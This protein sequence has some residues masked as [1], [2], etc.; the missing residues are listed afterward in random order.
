MERADLA[1]VFA[2][3]FEGATDD[4]CVGDGQLFEGSLLRH[5]GTND[6]WELTDEGA[7]LADFG[8]VGIDP[9]ARARHRNGVAVLHADGQILGQAAAR[10]VGL[11]F[12]AHAADDRNRSGAAVAV[13]HG[14]VGRFV[15]RGE[16]AA[17]RIDLHERSTVLGGEFITCSKIV[18]DVDTED[19][20][21]PLFGQIRQHSGDVGRIAVVV[22][23]NHGVDTAGRVDVGL[24]DGAFEDVVAAVAFEV[25]HGH[26]WFFVSKTLEK[27]QF[28]PSKRTSSVATRSRSS[29]RSSAVKAGYGP[30]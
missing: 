28:S 12:E 27:H 6:Q 5:A 16:V 22:F 30:Y 21:R 19:V 9:R 23:D 8:R 10:Q 24:D 20:L 11:V 26:D 17:D 3:V 18:E 4:G 7:E 14:V 13:D 2:G 15:G 25:Q 29:C 1:G